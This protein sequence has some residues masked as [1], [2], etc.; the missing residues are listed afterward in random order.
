MTNCNDDI[1]PI[2]H[3]IFNLNPKINVI[4]NPLKELAKPSHS[5]VVIPDGQIFSN[6]ILINT[7][8]GASYL[9]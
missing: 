2:G 5:F 6:S 7:K 3:V 8:C 1:A 9:F 4:L